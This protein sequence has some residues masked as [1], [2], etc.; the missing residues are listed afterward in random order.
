MSA[1]PRP[2][3]KL[4]FSRK[5]LPETSRAKNTSI[6]ASVRTFAAE[7]SEKPRNQNCEASAP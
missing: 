4:G 1:R 3:R 6:S 2:S 7:V 5:S